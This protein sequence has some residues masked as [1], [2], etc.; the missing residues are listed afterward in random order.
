MSIAPFVIPDWPAPARVRAVTTTRAWPGDWRDPA[1]R[2][3]LMETLGLPSP[4]RWLRQVH[5]TRVVDDHDF[6]GGASVEPEADAA[7]TRVP[8]VAL[9]IRTADCLPIVLASDDG[10][11]IAAIHA[12]WR[13]LAHGVIE[14]TLAR[15]RVPGERLVGWIGPCAGPGAYEVDAVVRDAFVERDPGATRAFR[16]SRPGHWWCDLPWLARRRLAAHGAI[17]VAGGGRCTIAEADA[18]YSWRRAAD[19]GRMATLVWIER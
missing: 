16:P 19:A 8:G 2:A 15:L 12:G 17:R 5:G 4:P 13:G 6:G 18:F 14:A 10:E 3:R 11:A 9:A 1:E 7:I